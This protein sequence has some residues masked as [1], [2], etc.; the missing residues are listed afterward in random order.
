KRPPAPVTVWARACQWPCVRPWS[1]TVRPATPGRTTPETTARRPASTPVWRVWAT[2]AAVTAIGRVD[3]ATGAV[4]A[5]ATGA[6]APSVPT[7]TR[8]EP[9]RTRR[10]ATR[11]A[12]WRPVFVLAS[13]PKPP[14]AGANSS[15]T[16]RPAAPSLDRPVTTTGRP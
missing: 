6:P 1:V 3:D 4:A 8:I 9:E 12:P 16:V 11:Y 7:V 2:I 15:V 10:A 13:A 5:P 14:P